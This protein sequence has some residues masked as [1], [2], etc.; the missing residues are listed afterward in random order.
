[1]FKKVLLQFV[2][3]GKLFQPAPPA[4]PIETANPDGVYIEQ[5][6]LL[7]PEHGD[8]EVEVA[9]W[10]LASDEQAALNLA[11]WWQAGALESRACPHI[12]VRHEAP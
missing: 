9:G 11:G 1:M 7:V 6:R 3:R 5:A 10:V 4:I 2:A 8:T 12:E